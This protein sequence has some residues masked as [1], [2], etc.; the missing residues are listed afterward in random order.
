M[1]EKATLAAGMPHF[2]S[3]I[4]RSWGRDTF[5]SI[6]GLLIDQSRLDEAE[7]L[8]LTFAS[9]IKEGIVPNLLADGYQYSQYNSRDSTWFWLNSIK[10]LCT[11]MGSEE[12][13]DRKIILNHD[14][15]S[16]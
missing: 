5:I 4:F 16:K 11:A 1:Q 6:K 3:G 9:A 15:N 8:I 14:Q 10:S 2:S 12:I 7:E 13:L